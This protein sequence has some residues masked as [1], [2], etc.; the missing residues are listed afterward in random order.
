[1]IINT[2]CPDQSPSDF[3][4]TRQSTGK[5]PQHG[6]SRG[7]NSRPSGRTC[8]DQTG[9]RG[10]VLFCQRACIGASLRSDPCARLSLL[11]SA[12]SKVYELPCGR[13][14]A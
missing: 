7:D 4:G 10:V 2:F 1:M 8:S 6:P 3:T 14:P 13:D 5:Q 12:Q 11:G 9:C